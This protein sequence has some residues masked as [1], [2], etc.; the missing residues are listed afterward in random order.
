[1]LS[2][3]LGLTDAQRRARLNRLKTTLS[4]Y[5][6]FLTASD[7]AEAIAYDQTSGRRATSSGASNGLYNSSNPN[8]ASGVVG[9]LNIVTSPVMRSAFEVFVGAD[10][11]ATPALPLP[12]E[13]FSNSIKEQLDQLLTSQHGDADKIEEL[14][15]CVIMHHT[16]VA[17]LGAADGKVCM[18][19]LGEIGGKVPDSLTA[20]KVLHPLMVPGNKNSELLSVF[21][22]SFPTLELTRATPVLN[23]TFYGKRPVIQD[24]KLTSITLSKFLEGAAQTGSNLPMKAIALAS[25]TSASIFGNTHEKFTNYSLAG[26][27]LFRAPQTLNNQESV[28]NVNNYLAPVIDPMRPLASIKGLSIDVVSSTG[29][30]QHKTAKLD[31]VLHDRSRLG[32]FADFVK[33]D[34]YGDTKIEIEYGWM[35]PDTPGTGTSDFVNP[36]AELL[37]L[38][39][40]K[41]HYGV[42]LSN[43]SFDDVGQVNITLSLYTQGTAQL[44]QISIVPEGGDLRERVARLEQI[45]REINQLTEVAFSSRGAPSGGSRRQEVRGQQMLVAAG[46]ATNHL[47]LSDELF[48]SLH[49]LRSRITHANNEHASQERRDALN[50]LQGHINEL[51]GTSTH[52]GS[53]HMVDVAGALGGIQNNVNQSINDAF[54]TINPGGTGDTS[55]SHDIFLKELDEPIRRQINRHRQNATRGEASSPIQAT[56]GE[57]TTNH[58]ARADGRTPYNSHDSN[59][60]ISLGTLILTFV[61]KPLANL[62]DGTRPKY[63]EVQIYFYSFNDKASMMSRCNIAQFP[64]YKDF[65]VREYARARLENTSRAVNFTIADFIAFVAN[66]MVDD[67]MNPA[68]RFDQLYKTAT[69]SDATEAAYANRSITSDNIDSKIEEVLRDPTLGNISGAT[70]FVMPQISFEIEALPS[71]AN[72]DETILKLHIYDRACSPNTSLHSLLNMSNTNMMAALSAY[73]NGSAAAT[74]AIAAA[75]TQEDT[76]YANAHGGH[77]PAGGHVSSTQ[78]IGDRLRANWVQIHNAVVAKAIAD[79]VI[80][81]LPGTEGTTNPQYTIAGGPKALKKLVSK[82]LPHII[83]GCMGTTVKN[84]NIASKTDSLLASVNMMRNLN[85]DNLQPNGQQ[86]GGIP[87]QVYPTD[88]SLTTLGCPFVTYSQEMFL[89]LNTN[90]T[91]DNTYIVNGISH[92]IEQGTFE[93]TLKLTASDAF[94]RYRSM[95]QQLNNAAGI[96]S[97]AIGTR[98]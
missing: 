40:Q 32:E 7:M 55:F 97:G 12:R 71:Q 83:Y 5:F 94:A 20:F 3:N 24:G 28:K 61:G 11:S 33:P 6:G 14:Q 22:N 68:Y 10:D 52:E 66:K 67:Q 26:M 95:I 36:Y 88:V 65:V 79:G 54:A 58:G 1:M 43:F 34:R 39:R 76:D 45:S 27:E 78:A 42:Q 93:T 9:M 15:R 98:T 60:V 90:T 30:M 23:I 17:S 16:T 2:L 63:A 41:E 19:D 75:R 70:D 80:T 29:L 25:Q 46:D 4:K 38:T 62:M 91:L 64:I 92:R 13:G 82:F 44:A 77:P 81:P 87:L 96:L 86:V 74:S 72:P 49:E 48:T 18:R 50:K 8:N 85:S 53:H 89:D 21:F 47:V 57:S 69:D 31:L 51:V 56:A 37:N 84:A 59:P 73:P 35:H